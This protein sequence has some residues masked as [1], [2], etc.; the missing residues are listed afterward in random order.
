MA[1]TTEEKSKK[2]IAK[3]VITPKRRYF[4]PNHGEVEAEDLTRVE[5]K[6]KQVNKKAEAGDGNK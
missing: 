3:R 1:K 2:T 5:A 4:V 6:L